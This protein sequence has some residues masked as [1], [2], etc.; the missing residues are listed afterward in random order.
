[1]KLPKVVFSLT[2]IGSFPIE[3]VEMMAKI[4]REAEA[5]IDY[6][7]LYPSIRRH[8]KLPI[9]HSE[10]I[11]SSA[12][13]TSWDV[14]A[15][16]IIVLSQTGNTAMKIAKYRPIAPVLAVTSSKIAANQCQVLRG[17]YPLLV[18]DMSGTD[19]IVHRAMLWGVK[20]GMAQRGDPVC[21]LVFDNRLL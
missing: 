2:F 4:C 16:L 9:P 21:F 13:K 3:A 12:V 14:H 1:V 8:V 20:M 6:S 5:D 10:A 11:A 15:A 19:N 7:E 17:I 18:N